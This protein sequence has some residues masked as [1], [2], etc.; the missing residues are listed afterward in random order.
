MHLTRQHG[1]GNLAGG[2]S[3]NKG[4]DAALAAIDM[5]SLRRQPPG[6]DGSG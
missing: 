5:V 2:K 4:A 3:G 1:A 6:R